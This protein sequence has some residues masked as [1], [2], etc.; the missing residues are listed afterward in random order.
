MTKMLTTTMLSSFANQGQIC[1]C[2]SR[3]FIERSI[4]EKFK[5]DFVA[6]TQKLTVGAPMDEKTKIGAVV[7]KPHMEKDFIVCG[8]S[9]TRGRKSFMWWQ[10]SKH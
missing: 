1:L 6:K 9:Q 10:A 3:I 5:T 4:Y 8:I 7:S 2:G